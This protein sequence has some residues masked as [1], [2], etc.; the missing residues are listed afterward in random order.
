MSESLEDGDLVS[1]VMIWILR[2]GQYSNS[3]RQFPT[4]TLRA[5]GERLAKGLDQNYSGHSVTFFG[6]SLPYLA[7]FRACY[8]LVLCA[9]GCR[10]P[11]NSIA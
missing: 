11:C 6:T 2:F 9:V 10:K 7:R 8:L 5:T 3:E 1:F 4:F